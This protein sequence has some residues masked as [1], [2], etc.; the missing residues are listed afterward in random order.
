MMNKFNFQNKKLNFYL[1]THIMERQLIELQSR[2]LNTM[3]IY[4]WSNKKRNILNELELIS[5]N[6][7]FM[8]INASR[9]AISGY[10]KTIDGNYEMYIIGVKNIMRKIN[11]HYALPT[12]ILKR[13]KSIRN[14]NLLIILYQFTP[15][16]T[17]IINKILGFSP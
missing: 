16:S 4:R 15:F 1:L 2:L 6:I 8:Y 13:K 14:N 3:Q 17:D 12:A 7:P 9:L 11:I 5:K 10:I